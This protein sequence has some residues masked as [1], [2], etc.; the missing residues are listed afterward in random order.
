MFSNYIS[1][2]LDVF[3]NE[4]LL[5]SLVSRIYRNLEFLEFSSDMNLDLLS[6]LV[7]SLE[8]LR[9]FNC[10]NSDEMILSLAK[11][12]FPEEVVNKLKS[13]KGTSI[14]SRRSKHMMVNRSTGETVYT[15]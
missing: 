5:D 9:L 2:H 15:L 3:K 14:P 7:Y 13:I 4:N 1:H 10:I 12:L 8:S 11:F 6:E